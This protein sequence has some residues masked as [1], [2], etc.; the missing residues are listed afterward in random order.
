MCRRLVSL[1]G[2]D[3][4]RGRSG[5]RAPSSGYFDITV[6]AKKS[7]LISVPFAVCV[8][9][10]GATAIGLPAVTRQMRIALAK[11]AVPLRSSLAKLDK[12]ALGPYRFA[13]ANV[14][15]P[16]VVDALGTTD[17][18]DWILEDTSC[19]DLSSPLRYAR[20][21][22][23]Y[24]TGQPDAVPHTPDVCMVGAG[25]EIVRNENT[26]LQVSTVA[27]S[28]D[29]PVRLVTF[30]KSAIF[31]ADEMP[32]VYTFH[33]NG[34]FA[35]TRERVRTAVNNP[36]DAYAYYSK[37]EVGF[38]W[39]MARPHFPPRDEA[40]AATAKMFSY[41]LPLLIE[42]HWPDWNALNDATELQPG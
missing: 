25:Y 8:V 17:Y 15:D 16:A 10:L 37:I 26:T 9:V 38:G 29:V 34:K 33:C 2:P 18:I 20:L 36:L 30:V 5:L 28:P 23:T 39:S 32:I 6:Q 40:L 11:G 27:D 4:W 7:V 42:K 22:V 31:G 1:S 14:L 24:Y 41:V 13:S 3:A 12:N 21:H 35:A 19:T